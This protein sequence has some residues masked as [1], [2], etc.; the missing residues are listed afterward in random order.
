[1]RLILPIDI[2]Y[3]VLFTVFNSLVVFIRAQRSSL[4][5]ADY[6]F[7]YNLINTVSLL[8]ANAYLSVWV[9]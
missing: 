7:Y 4:P 8:S 3:A 2:S 9:K 5:L 6:R 1:M